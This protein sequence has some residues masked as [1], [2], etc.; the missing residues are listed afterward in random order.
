MKNMNQKSK[1][2]QLFI[3]MLLFLMLIGVF[4]ITGCG[5]KQSCETPKCG[6]EDFGAGTAIGCSIPGCGGCISSGKGC[7][8]ACWPQSCKMVHA[9]E[10]EIQERIDEETNEETDEKTDEKTVKSITSINA[11][12]ACDIRYYD[13]GGCLGCNQ[14]EKNCYTGCIT[15]EDSNN[16]MNGI[17]YSTDSGEKIIGCINGCGGCVGSGGIGGEMMY[18]LESITGVD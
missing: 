6:S 18:E 3:L 15:A 13:G 11:I 12:T 17:F 16:D 4:C 14:K 2:E 9:S 8:A 10:V 1:S 7:N 5:N